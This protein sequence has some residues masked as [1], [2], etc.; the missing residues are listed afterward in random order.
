VTRVV[1]WVEAHERELVLAA[2]VAAVLVRLAYAAVA[3]SPK[4]T[5]D[6]TSF[7]AVAGNLVHGHGYSYEGSATAWR[8]P[9]Y[10]FAL[11]ALRG[12]GLGVRGVQVVQALVGASVPWLFHRAAGRLPVPAWL[13]VA[14]AWAAALYPPFVHIASQAL[15][16]NAS[17]PLLV[18]AVWASLVLLDAPSARH[19][20]LTGAAWGAAVLARPAAL[21]ALAVFGIALLARRRIAVAAAVAAVTLLVLFPWEVR[22][23]RAGGVGGAVPVVS[24]ESF[25]LWVSNRADA[26]GYKDVFRDPRY[27]G[28]EDYGVY[29]RAF[30]GIEKLAARH[31]FDF[32][33]AS[34]AS[35]DRWFRSL[36]V[37]DVR[38]DPARFVSRGAAKTVAALQ[39]APGNAS[40]EEKTSKAAKAVLWVTSGPLELL[41]LAGVAWL[42]AGGTAKERFLAGAALVSLVGLAVHL[43]YVRYRVGAV[44]PLLILAAASLLGRV[45][46]PTPDPAR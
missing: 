29:G 9:V 11:A 44:D 25:T 2:V 37:H 24:N 39:P 30:P 13:A 41:G 45:W 19:A 40:R 1:E 16:E 15:S 34:E 18:L 10:T 7:W 46:R 12:I 32:D 22:D 20:V 6:E 3:V 38:S 4:L 43:P 35:R 5:D 26:V 23:V 17:L 42:L 33:H 8:P 28:L 27:P 21:P 31:H 14:A 36:V